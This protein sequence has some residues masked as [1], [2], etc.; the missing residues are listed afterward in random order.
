MSQQEKST[1]RSY[2]KEEL[3]NL[4]TKLELPVKSKTTKKA[5]VEILDD[6]VEKHPEELDNIEKILQTEE[7]EEDDDDEDDDIVEVVK[8]DGEEDEDEDDD[9]EEEEGDEEE[10]EEEEAEDDEEE[11][12]EDDK[13]YEA[14]PPLNLKEWVVDPII[15]QSET[16]IEK[17]Y[18]FTDNVGITYLNQS[19]KLRDQLSSTVTLN[20]LQIGVELLIFIYT[21]IRVVPLNENNLIHQI[22]HDNIPYLSIITWPS[23][24][25]S[26]IF[27]YTSIITFIIW[28]ITSIIIPSIVSY[29]INFTSRVIEIED[30]EYL[31]RVYSF[32]P[33]I[34]AL[35]KILT[36]YFIGQ[37]ALIE[38]ATC[39]CFISAIFNKTL[40]NIGLYQ[41]FAT[42]NLGTLPYVLGGV[43]VL[44]ALYAQFEEY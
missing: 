38:F 18:E 25:I 9:D 26:S 2:T 11:E 34:F 4:L 30:D 8:I 1:F 41:S 23:L 40:L 29:F 43:N 27:Q 35:S 5:M 16:F 24:E 36:F 28:S 6:F 37:F 42:N 7:D 20:Y 13:D 22:F 32:D 15:A 17:F 14:P 33:F 12:E 10:E 31:F 39:E 44:I 19:E 3:H 21:F